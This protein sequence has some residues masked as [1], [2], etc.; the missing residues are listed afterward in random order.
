MKNTVIKNSLIFIVI[1]IMLPSCSSSKK[2]DY[3]HNGLEVTERVREFVA[4]HNISGSDLD[5]IHRIIEL[6][7][8]RFLFVRIDRKMIQE[9]MRN[10]NSV[11]EFKSNLSKQKGELDQLHKKREK[12]LLSEEEFKRRKDLLR[13]IFLA[14]HNIR[15]FD[16][17]ISKKDIYPE[18]L[19]F[20]VSGAEA[21]EYGISDGCTTATK[22]FIVL[23]KAAGLKELRLVCSGNTEDY[24]RACPATG[25]L[26]KEGVTIN[27]HF[28]ALAKIGGKWAL[29]NCTY[30]E[31]YA[32]D[33]N[34]KYEI[35][36]TLDGNEITPD[37]IQF[38]T[39]RVPSFQREAT[40]P[41]P[42]V[43]YF[44]GVGRD[45]DDDMNIEN[46]RAL[47]NLSVSG[48]RDCGTCR[49]DPFPPE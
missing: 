43:L 37:T 38:K 1:V 42:K 16:T 48:D 6:M 26:R 23:A 9:W 29:V 30:F 19:P 10:P 20:V 14:E 33:D 49:L 39:I 11:E 41:P 8:D 22:A 27:G 31:P 2:K 47:M 25:E 7:H 35:F 34:I 4:R 40:P 36:F 32:E 5:K 12:E 15:I 3:R 46:Y 13:S 17:V 21:V 24:N 45:S 28:F 44:A 18:G